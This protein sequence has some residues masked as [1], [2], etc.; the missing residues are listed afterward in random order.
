MSKKLRFAV[1][2]KTSAKQRGQLYCCL[3]LA[4]N[5]TLQLS[6]CFKLA[7]IVKKLKLVQ[8]TKRNCPVAENWR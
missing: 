1:L 6:F 2:G 8:E 5:D 4:P 7:R 3:K